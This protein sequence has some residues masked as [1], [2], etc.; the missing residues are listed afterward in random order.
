VICKP[1]KGESWQPVAR[2][3]E[4][5][6]YEV[7]T[8]FLPGGEAAKIRVIATD[9]FNTTE[10]VSS[11][12]FMV[13]GKAPKGFI[14]RPEAE[15]Q[16]SAGEPISLEGEATDLEDGPIPDASFIWS[17]DSTVFGTGRRVN[18]RLSEGVHE[19]TLTVFDS[20]GNRGQDTVLIPVGI[21]DREEKK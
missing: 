13:K 9:G 6:A 14:I 16:F 11:G 20:D 8:S 2:N 17:Y 5:E 15:T 4:G 18:A 7:D 19:V 10:A 21:P 12:T 1:S 3:L